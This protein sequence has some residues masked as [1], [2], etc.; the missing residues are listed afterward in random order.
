MAQYS[1]VNT[2][3]IGSNGFKKDPKHPDVRGRINVDGIWY[4]VSGWNKQANGNE[5]TSLALTIMT[6]EQVDEMMRKREEKAKAK[7]QPQAGAQQQRQQP[8]AQ[9]QQAPVQQQQSN[10]NPDEPKDFDDDIPF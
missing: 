1:D 7:A 4:W 5:F 9:Q 2:G 8:S 10:Y 6:Q 3:I